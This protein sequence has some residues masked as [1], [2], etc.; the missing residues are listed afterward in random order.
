M[1]SQRTSLKE[2]RLSVY[3]YGILLFF[4]KQT[5]AYVEAFFSY[6]EDFF[7]HLLGHNLIFRQTPFQNQS[8]NSSTA[9]SVN[10]SFQ[11]IF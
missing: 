4:L 2:S 8:K 7:A 6:V 9:K 5:M 1:V 11:H 10:K 3:V